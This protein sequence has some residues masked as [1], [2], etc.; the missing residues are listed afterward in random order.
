[1]QCNVTPCTLRSGTLQKKVSL[2]SLLS[3]LAEAGQAVLVHK[4]N[5]IQH[6][7]LDSR[8]PTRKSQSLGSPVVWTHS[9]SG[10]VTGPKA[11][12]LPRSLLTRHLSLGKALPRLPASFPS[13]YP[14]FTP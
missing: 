12:A 7:T 8:G 1:M 3:A 13:G 10:W 14:D 9:G 2:S 5:S 6:V 4:L 11:G